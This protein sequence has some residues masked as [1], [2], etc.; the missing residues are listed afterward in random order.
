MIISYSFI[1]PQNGKTYVGKRDGS[2]VREHVL[3]E[4]VVAE[5]LARLQKHVVYQEPGYRAYDEEAQK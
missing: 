4:S 2:Q 3:K 1:N 5:T